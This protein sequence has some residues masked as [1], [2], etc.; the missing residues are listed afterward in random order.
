MAMRYPQ[1]MS[2]KTKPDPKQ[3]TAK[4]LEIPV[5]IRGEV[6]AA[7]RKMANSKELSIPRRRL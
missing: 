2:G 6:D 1:D 7:L 4:G 5:T 3:K